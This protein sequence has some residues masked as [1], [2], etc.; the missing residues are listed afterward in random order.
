MSMFTLAFNMTNMPQTSFKELSKK[1]NIPFRHNHR[2]C[3]EAQ[4]SM[5]YIAQ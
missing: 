4:N 5:N 2:N 3:Y 1:T